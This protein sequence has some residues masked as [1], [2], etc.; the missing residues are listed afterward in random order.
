MH[1]AAAAQPPRPDR[2][3]GGGGGGRAHRISGQRC[4]GPPACSDSESDSDAPSRSGFRIAAK[5]AASAQRLPEET[6]D[7]VQCNVPGSLNASRQ[8]LAAA[9]AGDVST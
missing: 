1:P 2:G 5:A 7:S 4:V 8:R 3:G 9:A 6:R